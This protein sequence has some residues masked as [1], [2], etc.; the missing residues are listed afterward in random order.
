M[1]TIIKST[2]NDKSK[3]KYMEME[4]SLQLFARQSSGKTSSKGSKGFWDGQAISYEVS[5]TGDGFY[6]QGK[7][8]DR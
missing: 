1:E 4:K 2:M 3:M 6:G 5:D 8:K 7:Y